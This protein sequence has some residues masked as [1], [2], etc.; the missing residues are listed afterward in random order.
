[1]K[2]KTIDELV[3]G[4]R[5]QVS[6]PGPGQ[7]GCDWYDGIVIRHTQTRTQTLVHVEL[8][9][10]PRRA[11]GYFGVVINHRDLAIGLVRSL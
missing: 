2:I 5:V 6:H 7:I 1:M 10:H 3:I 9:G 11:S 4:R 8:V